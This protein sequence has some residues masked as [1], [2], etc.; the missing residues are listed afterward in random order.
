MNAQEQNEM[1]ALAYGEM[2]ND[3]EK[4]LAFI[5]AEPAVAEKLA[6]QYAYDAL[7]KRVKMGQMLLDNPDKMKAFAEIIYDQL[8]N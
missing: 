5:G 3:R 8:A 2:K 4:L 6:L 7:Q 1:A